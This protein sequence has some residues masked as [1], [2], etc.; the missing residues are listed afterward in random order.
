MLFGGIMFPAMAPNMNPSYPTRIG[1]FSEKI[2]KKTYQ[3]TNDS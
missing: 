2:A 1:S 3:G